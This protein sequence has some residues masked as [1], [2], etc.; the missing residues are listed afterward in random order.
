MDAFMDS[1]EGSPAEPAEPAEGGKQPLANGHAH[2]PQP[3]PQPQP[4]KPPEAS[5]DIRT[6][7][8][9]PRP[10]TSLM[11]AYVTRRWA[12]TKTFPPWG[13]LNTRLKGH[14]VA[15]HSTV[16]LMPGA[17]SVYAA[18]SGAAP[19]TA[20]ELSTG[21]PQDICC[22]LSRTCMLRRGHRSHHA[23]GDSSAAQPRPVLLPGQPGGGAVQ[24]PHPACPGGPRPVLLC[25][26]P[27]R[28]WL[29]P[30]SAEKQRP[31]AT[32]TLTG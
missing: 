9:A 11:H 2:P 6:A 7:A 19:R 4:A 3:A 10:G 25:A 23:A 13:L 20:S 15:G 24:Q 28:A 1:R 32:R 17:H 5:T 8:P 18:S 12:Q 26:A 29:E 31:Q 27:S 22:R 14:Q 16:L 30:T 21:H